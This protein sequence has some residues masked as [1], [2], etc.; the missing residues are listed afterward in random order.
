MWLTCKRGK[1]RTCIRH[2]ERFVQFGRLCCTLSQA[3]DLLTVAASESDT[4]QQIVAF[5]AQPSH[6]RVKVQLWPPWL[7]VAFSL[8]TQCWGL[9][10]TA[11]LVLVCRQGTFPYYGVFPF[12][13][14]KY[15]G[16]TISLCTAHPLSP[17]PS[18]LLA[19]SPCVW[20]APPL[21]LH[22]Q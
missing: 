12:C 4:S 18:F 9:K 13:C 8:S 7:C 5:C 15:P 22:K 16:M 21:S 14:G 20:P 2:F 17:P 19:S 6:C 10:R 11:C 3:T 1:E